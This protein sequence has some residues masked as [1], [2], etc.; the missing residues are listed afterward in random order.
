MRAILIAFFLFAV[1]ST[2]PWSTAHS[3]DARAEP[4]ALPGAPYGAASL[5]ASEVIQF[6]MC[7][8]SAKIQGYTAKDI[9][10]FVTLVPMADAEIVRLQAD[11][12]A[13][14]Q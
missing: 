9:H 10:G 3:P 4:V 11:G 13:Y 8:A 1:F 6:R 2:V 12:Y 14:M 5:I 7:G